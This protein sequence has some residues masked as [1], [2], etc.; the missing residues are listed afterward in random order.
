MKSLEES[1]NYNSF[2]KDIEKDFGRSDL[3][4]SMGYSNNITLKYDRKIYYAYGEEAEE[5]SEICG[6]A[7]NTL[8][9]KDCVVLIK[10]EKLYYY[11][12]KLLKAGKKI[13]II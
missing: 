10:E 13:H 3:G 12:P 1:I 8:K 4:K 6:I 2:F 11:L 7:T 9:G 5:V